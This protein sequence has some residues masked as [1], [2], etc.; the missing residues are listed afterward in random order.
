MKDGYCPKCKCNIVVQGVRVL[1]RGHLDD[2]HDLS[3][4]AYRKPD[5][6]LFK[7]EVACN[8]WA[9]VCGACGYTELYAENPAE[10]VRAANEAQS[11]EQTD[12]GSSENP[13]V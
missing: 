9:C 12:A 3:V 11:R 13:G 7:G 6:W 4:V 2:A 1:D 10:L 8:L 5:A